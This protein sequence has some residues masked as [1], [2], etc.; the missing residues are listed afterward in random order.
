MIKLN[1][2]YETARQTSGRLVQV[3]KKY[4]IEEEFHEGL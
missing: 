1:N 3:D 2:P 4:N